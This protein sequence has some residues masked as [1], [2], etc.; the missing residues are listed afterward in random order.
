MPRGSD[1]TVWM[2]I[3]SRLGPDFGAVLVS[4][5]IAAMAFGLVVALASVITRSFDWRSTR[6]AHLMV[7]L[8]G[9]T[10]FAFMSGAFVLYRSSSAWTESERFELYSA[11]F[12]GALA[13]AASTIAF[14]KL[15]GAFSL[16]RAARP[17]H[18]VVNLFAI[19]LGGWLGYGFVT[20]QAQPFGLAALI[21]ASALACAIG[22]HLTTSCEYDGGHALA[23]GKQGLMACIEW[24]G[25]DEPAWVLREITPGNVRA[26]AY[27]HRRDWHKSNSRNDGTGAAGRSRSRVCSHRRLTQFST[28]RRP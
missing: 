17:G 9:S 22:V 7:M 11:V 27:R 3:C 28:R 6:R 1:S 14:C 4:A 12:M 21:A 25:G 26:A 20:E 15:C 13:F 10:G 16:K 18:N 23:A 5:L 8:G 19:L 24:H 2:D